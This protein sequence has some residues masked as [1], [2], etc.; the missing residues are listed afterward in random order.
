[1]DVIE[2]KG[3]LKQYFYIPFYTAIVLLFFDVVTFIYNKTMGIFF[4]L[5][6][7]LY[8]LILII[9]YNIFKN[10]FVHEIIDFATK[11]SKMQSILIDK[12]D[13]PYVLLDLSLIHI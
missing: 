12:F 4:F 8:F 1:M 2:Y 10:K 6:V 9:F 5:I 3:Q 7:C 11:C 13:V